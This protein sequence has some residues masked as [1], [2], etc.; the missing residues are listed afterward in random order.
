MTPRG[1]AAKL[2][3]PVDAAKVTEALGDFFGGDLKLAGDG[4][5]GG[6]VEHVV[7]AGDMK[8]EGP[9]RS[10]CR[11]GPGSARSGRRH[12]GEK[13]EAVVG[14]GGIAVGEDAAANAG[15]NAP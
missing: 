3:A 12:S 5:G 11:C 2:K 1:G 6:G 9:E 10:G 7:A 4:D 14:L 8:L 15:Q 13:F